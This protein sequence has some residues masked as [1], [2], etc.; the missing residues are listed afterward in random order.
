MIVGLL[1]YLVFTWVSATVATWALVVCL[2][3]TPSAL[4]LWV[5]I[6]GNPLVPM[7]QLHND[8]L[9]INLQIYELRCD[10]QSAA[11]T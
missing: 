10:H 9:P 11:S 7:L 5:F 1:F 3:Y 8:Q 2:I 6:S 4:V